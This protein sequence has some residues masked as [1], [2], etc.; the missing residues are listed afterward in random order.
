MNFTISSECFIC[1]LA[2]WIAGLFFCSWTEFLCIHLPPV[3]SHQENEF[4][5]VVACFFFGMSAGLNKGIWMKHLLYI[6]LITKDQ[7]LSCNPEIASY[8][9]FLKQNIAL[10]IVGLHIYI[11]TS[12]YGFSSVSCISGRREV[13]LMQC[14]K[15]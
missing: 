13:I 3:T 1:Y 7:K 11:D 15:N 9:I 14:F 8:Y 5:L 10:E 6:N 2:V 4:C 12:R